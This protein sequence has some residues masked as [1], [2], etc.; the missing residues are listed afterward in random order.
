MPAPAEPAVPSQAA[1]A[2][3]AWNDVPELVAAGPVVPIDH[4][5]GGTGTPVEGHFDPETHVAVDS[6][7]MPSVADLPE[8]G[9]QPG[10]AVAAGAA[11][12]AAIDPFAEYLDQQQPKKA[13]AA[14]AKPAENDPWGD[15]EELI[16]FNKD[17]SSSSGGGAR[18]ASH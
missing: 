18:S 6:V 9:A 11:A 7:R 2:A 12:A 14:P 4:G 3:T 5:H 8:L 15:L 13:D 17:T 16:G 10:P 1:V